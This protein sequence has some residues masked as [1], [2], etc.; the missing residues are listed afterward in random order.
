MSRYIRANII[1]HSFRVDNKAS[2]TFSLQKYVIFVLSVNKIKGKLGGDEI[3]K[4]IITH[5][6]IHI[7]YS[8]NVMLKITKFKILY[9]PY[10]LSDL[11]QIFTV[12]FEILYSF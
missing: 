1:L 6:H 2:F 7:D 9:L 12:L 10:F 11:H 4:S 8:R 5:L 3:N